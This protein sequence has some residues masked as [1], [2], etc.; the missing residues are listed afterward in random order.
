MRNSIVVNNHGR[1]RLAN[2]WTS[3]ALRFVV[4]GTALLALGAGALSVRAAESG[5]SDSV[6]ATV[7][8]HKITEKDLDA[9]IKPQM[10]QLEARVIE[11][12]RQ[13]LDSMADQYLVEQAASK[14]GL[15]PD[16]YL[17]KEVDDKVGK[18]TEADAKKFF[19]DHKLQDRY[20]YAEVK[21]RVIALLD[22]QRIQD[23][24]K[25][26]LDELRAATPVKILLETPRVTVNS[27]GHPTLGAASAP[28][29]VVEFGDFQCPFCG[30]AEAS[31]KELRAK[32]GD[33]IKLVFMDFPLPSHNHAMDAAKA[34]RC[35]NE[36][37]K[38]WPYHDALFA[39]QTK[40]APADLKAT[41]K[42]LGLDTAKFDSCLDKGKY[43]AAVRAD[44]KYGQELGI[45]GTPTFYIDGRS[46]I[47][48][49]PPA[50]FAQII[51]DELQ[52]PAAQQAASR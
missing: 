25:E 46:L 9:K 16:A 13:A 33:K 29:T 23:R 44:Q 1:R 15:S 34:A 47:G 8:N 5:G 32:Y 52:H 31:L 26:L 24:R 4:L 30:R 2:G 43:E 12:K 42:R 38:F 10:A 14:A 6:V 51:D 7:G 21:D 50:Q 20:K 19:D 18:A 48:A 36:Q 45:D 27:A 35:A 49:Q 3:A 17:K 11:L 28:V 37:D 40:L 41:A 39:D 22:R